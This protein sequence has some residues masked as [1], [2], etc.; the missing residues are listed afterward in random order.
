MDC[1][2]NGKHS[3][4]TSPSFPEGWQDVGSGSG[5]RSLV[6]VEGF[7]FGTVVVRGD[8]TGEGLGDR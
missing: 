6:R 5:A 2:L 8:V 4:V 3:R 7:T 1:I